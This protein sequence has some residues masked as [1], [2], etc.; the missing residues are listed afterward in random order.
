MPLPDRLN[1][2]PQ[3]DEFEDCTCPFESEVE[4]KGCEKYA[5]AQASFWRERERFEQRDDD[6]ADFLRDEEKDRIIHEDRK[7]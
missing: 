1:Y 2:E 5:R 4:C 6:R 7:P 3:R